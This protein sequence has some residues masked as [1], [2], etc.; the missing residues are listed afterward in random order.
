MYQIKNGNGVASIKDADVKQGIVTGYFSSFGNIDSD[1]DIIVKGAFTKTILETGPQ[2][3]QPRIKHLMN[4]DTTK[5]LGKLTVLQEDMKGLYYE[6]KTGSHS[7]GQDYMKMVESGLITEHSIGFKTIK[8]DK[9]DDANYMTELRLWEGSSL[10]A[11][12]SNPETPVTGMKSL[13]LETINSRIKALDK[14]CRNST[15]TDETIELLLIEIKQLQQN[16]IEAT[17]SKQITLPEV[18]RDWKTLI[19]L[20]N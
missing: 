2:S 10:T 1:G 18:K 16:L 11:W 12:G 3:A 20:L 4:H 15:A 19:N 8:E 17:E 9:K 7:L 13:N 5:P 6:S 14:F